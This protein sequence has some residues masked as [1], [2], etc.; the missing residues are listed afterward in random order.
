MESNVQNNTNT[1][2][3]NSTA[4]VNSAGPLASVDTNILGALA[5]LLG[6]ISGIVVFLLEKD[7]KSVKFHAMQAILFSVATFVISMAVNI[8]VA[9]ILGWGLAT[10]IS[11]LVSL[12]TFVIWIFLMWKAYQNVEYELPI[13]GPIAKKQVYQ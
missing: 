10:S 12:A 3:P 1:S 4:P 6:F 11:T 2:Q 13:I 8:V 9:P 7:R 5:Y